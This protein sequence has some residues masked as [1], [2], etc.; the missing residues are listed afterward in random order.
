MHLER[1]L[2]EMED[3]QKA[4]AAAALATTTRVMW[5]CRYWASVRYLSF[6]LRCHHPTS[7]QLHA[8][9][10]LS[11]AQRYGLY[12]NLSTEYTHCGA[13]AKWMLYAAN[14]T[15]RVDAPLIF[16]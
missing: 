9:L 10:T 8:C 12:S 1:A 13:R 11:S 2:A 5:P 7:V 4:A 16:R 3:A 15:E 14:E 6:F